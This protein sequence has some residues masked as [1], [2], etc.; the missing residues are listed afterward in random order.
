MKHWKLI[1]GLLCIGFAGVYYVWSLFAP[2]LLPQTDGQKPVLSAS[3]YPIAFALERIA[4]EGYAVRSVTPGGVEPHDFEPSPQDVLRMQQS[5]VLF[6][7]GAGL[8]PWVERVETALQEKQV[9]MVN[10][11]EELRQA[12]FRLS[13]MTEGEHED[14]HG[15]EHE[16]GIY[17]PHVWLDPVAMEQIGV[18]IAAALTA[19]FPQ[20]EA[21][22][23]ENLQQWRERMQA[24]HQE[25]TSGLQACRLQEII[26]SHDAFSYLG[27]RYGFDIISIAGFSPQEQPSAKRLGELADLARE[28]GIRIVYFETLASPK[29]SEALANEV[30]AATSVL[31]PI[32]GISQADAQSG[33]TYESIMRDNLQALR[34]GLECSQ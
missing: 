24:L 16:D 1:V 28:K 8:D 29:L 21:M 11:T 12:G 22:F 20:D 5:A 18:V 32:E 7:N 30:G 10:V 4:G 31:D 25:Y 6:Y 19:Q 17:D 9:K 27:L 3:F 23:E 26:V 34:L 14:E 13:E 33:K 15:E 2:K